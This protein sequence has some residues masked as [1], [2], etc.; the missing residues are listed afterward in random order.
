MTR[1]GTLGLCCVYIAQLMTHTA[2]YTLTFTLQ[3]CYKPFDIL[4]RVTKSQRVHISS[5][6]RLI[7][8]QR[9]IFTCNTNKVTKNWLCNKIMVQVKF[10]FKRTFINTK[11]VTENWFCNKIMVQVKFRFKRT[12]TNARKVTKIASVI[13]SWFRLLFHSRWTCIYFRKVKTTIF[14][15]TI[16]LVFPDYLFFAFKI[17]HKNFMVFNKICHIYSTVQQLSSKAH[18]LIKIYIIISS[19]RLYTILA[20]DI[21][22]PNKT[23]FLRLIFSPSFIYFEMIFSS[24]C[25][26]SKEG[27]TSTLG[28]LIF[29][30]SQMLRF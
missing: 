2:I 8:K 29:I 5:H 17:S 15:C 22:P 13:R 26:P 21:H 6:N 9:I 24:S 1:R 28:K 4:Q 19:T 23:L 27:T 18:Q 11:K 10:C 12:F 30:I 20:P 3:L 25:I 7:P 16:I 14:T